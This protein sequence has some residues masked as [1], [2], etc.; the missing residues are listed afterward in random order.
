MYASGPFTRVVFAY[1]N[2]GLHF[3]VFRNHATGAAG[4]LVTT[5]FSNTTPINW[6]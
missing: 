5:I 2:W 1:D 6:R 4:D 3:G